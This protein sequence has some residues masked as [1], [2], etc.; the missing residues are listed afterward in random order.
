MASYEYIYENGIQ[1][2]VE[3]TP[4]ADYYYYQGQLHRENGPA[5][6]WK[7][8]KKWHPN[9]EVNLDKKFNKH[10]KEEWYLYNI[11]YTEEEHKKM[12]KF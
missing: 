8:D 1:L 5:I 2:E 10:D 7:E 6:I 4:F 12:M 11:R 9:V 3:S